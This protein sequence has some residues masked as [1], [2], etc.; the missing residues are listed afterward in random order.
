VVHFSF[1]EAVAAI[2]S[3][4]WTV[5]SP[6]SRRDCYFTWFDSVMSL[7]LA[8]CMDQMWQD[9]TC[10]G[11]QLWHVR[12]WLTKD[13]DQWDRSDRGWVCYK[14]THLCG[15][16]NL[17]FLFAPVQ[18]PA[19]MPLHKMLRQVCRAPLPLSP[20]IVVRFSEIF[21]VNRNIVLCCTDWLSVVL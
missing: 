2:F 11:R 7:L 21:A 9:P 6:A 15:A 13:S 8:T 5:L 14:S 1:C 3:N 10:I 12:Q 19:R 17:R 20:S 4:Y 18:L 16:W